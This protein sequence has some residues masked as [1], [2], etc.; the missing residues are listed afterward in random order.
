MGIERVILAAPR[1]F[2]GGV[3]R[4]ID[5]VN[6]ALE[7]YGSPV[8]VRKE[9]VHNAH[10]VQE[11]GGRG[12]GFVD[13]L[14]EVPAGARVILS[15]HGIAPEVRPQAAATGPRG[16]AATCPLVPRDPCEAA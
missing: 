13:D 16:I 10:V 2:W 3:D 8:Y 14:E 7:L 12:A 9:I 15:A 5:I 1:G 4:A 6:L 11:L